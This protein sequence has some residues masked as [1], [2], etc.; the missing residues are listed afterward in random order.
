LG[1]RSKF[2][3]ETF[4]EEAIHR[5]RQR[6]QHHTHSVGVLILDPEGKRVICALPVSAARRG[7]EVLVP[8]Q[9]KLVEGESVHRVA[10]RLA[11]SVLTYRLP[12]E[13]VRYLGSGFGSKHLDANSTKRRAK[14]VHWYGHVLPSRYDRRHFY[15]LLVQENDLF[16]RTQWLRIQQL[17]EIHDGGVV[18]DDKLRLMMQ[19]IWVLTRSEQLRE[20]MAAR[21][22]GRY[23]DPELIPATA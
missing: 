10:E 22:A 16:S 13:S 8:P 7:V 15:Q 1:K 3:T 2:T 19:A 5:A 9:E 12:T 17:L 20:S 6:N 23:L 11:Q 18:S 21:A 4:P 14:Y